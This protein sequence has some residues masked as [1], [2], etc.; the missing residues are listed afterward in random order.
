MQA[1][2]HRRS[3]PP[4]VDNVFKADIFT[5]WPVGPEGTLSSLS[6]ATQIQFMIHTKIQPFQQFFF[7]QEPSLMIQKNSC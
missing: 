2:G 4:T 1:Y 6:C 5:P 7:T 3:V